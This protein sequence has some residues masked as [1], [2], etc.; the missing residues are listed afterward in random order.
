MLLFFVRI[1]ILAFRTGSLTR[2]LD[3]I[4]SHVRVSGKS[5][6]GLVTIRGD[7]VAHRMFRVGNTA[8][9]RSHFRKTGRMRRKATW[10]GK[11]IRG[12][13][14]GRDRKCYLV[15]RCRFTMTVIVRVTVTPGV[16]VGTTVIRRLKMMQGLARPSLIVIVAGRLCVVCRT[17]IIHGTGTRGRRKR[18]VWG[19]KQALSRRRRVRE[20]PTRNPFTFRAVTLKTVSHLS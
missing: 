19:W 18:M 2:L 8:A 7:S 16:H 15:L 13:G 10:T 5:F 9:T 12:K 20:L 6:G 1:P 11:A 3:G 4:V 14:R 17:G